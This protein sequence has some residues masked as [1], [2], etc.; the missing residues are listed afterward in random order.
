LIRKHDSQAVCAG[1][2]RD[3]PGREPA[4]E[5]LP[6]LSGF[7]S[8]VEGSEDLREF[9]ANPHLRSGGEKSVIEQLLKKTDI[10]GVTAIF[11]KLLADKQRIV[12]LK[13]IV[14]ATAR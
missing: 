6:E 14:D 2:L 3:C 7:S 10:S 13:D 4:G 1:F 5:L 11:L 8:I 9:L 12:I